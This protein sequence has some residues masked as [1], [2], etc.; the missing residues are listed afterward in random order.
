M[1]REGPARDMMTGLWPQGTRWRPA[2]SLRYQ[3]RE[4]WRDDT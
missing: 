1:T 2:V 4:D 3:E